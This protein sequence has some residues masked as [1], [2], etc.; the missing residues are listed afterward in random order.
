MHLIFFSVR[1]WLKCHWILN[2][3]GK[4]LLL[5]NNHLFIRINQNPFNLRKICILT[6]SSDTAFSSKQIVFNIWNSMTIKYFVHINKEMFDNYRDYPVRSPRQPGTARRAQTPPP[7][8]QTAFKTASASIQQKAL[9]G[10]TNPWAS[11]TALALGGR[12]PWP[13]SARAWWGASPWCSWWSGSCRASFTWV[14]PSAPT[15]S[16]TIRGFPLGGIGGGWRGWRKDGV[17]NWRKSSGLLEPKWRKG[18]GLRCP[19]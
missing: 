14:F 9:R 15:P 19:F 7:S 13:W 17:G 5:T 12:D 6:N 2:T 18:I 11:L 8:T 16:G 1:W 3:E 4:I 10:S